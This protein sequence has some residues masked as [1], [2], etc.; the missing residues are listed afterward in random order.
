MQLDLL[1]GFVW[2]VDVSFVPYLLGILMNFSF[3]VA[4]P[5]VC[6][7]GWLCL[8]V[9]QSDGGP[10]CGTGWSSDKYS[11]WQKQVQVKSWD[12]REEC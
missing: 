1:D 4:A 11:C 12:I 3:Y 10:S 7:M 6:V 5:S 9:L 2:Y 8:G